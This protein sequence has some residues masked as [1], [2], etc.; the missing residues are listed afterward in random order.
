MDL[1][2]LL[3][4]TEM[5]IWYVNESFTI[6]NHLTYERVSYNSL[7]DIVPFDIYIPPYIGRMRFSTAYGSYVQASDVT[8]DDVDETFYEFY[9]RVMDQF[10]RKYNG[11]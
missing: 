1:F 4:S 5:K 2:D 10:G 6:L 11:V 9:D 8:Y 3:K 7:S